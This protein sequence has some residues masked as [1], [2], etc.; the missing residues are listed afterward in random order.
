MW[1]PFGVRSHKNHK[2]LL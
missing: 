1:S 2:P